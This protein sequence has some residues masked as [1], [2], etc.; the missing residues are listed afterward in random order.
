MEPEVEPL[1][2]VETEIEPLN[3]MTGAAENLEGL[4][5]ATGVDNVDFSTGVE[6]ES[7][8][9]NSVA[10]EFEQLQGG[11]TGRLTPS[12]EGTDIVSNI[13]RNLIGES[14]EIPEVALASR[15]SRRVIPARNRPLD[16]QFEFY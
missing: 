16:H 10:P 6:T 1:N 4:T 12:I 13:E 9:E 14:I 5:G 8:R 11:A 2:N 15:R 7:L 3:L